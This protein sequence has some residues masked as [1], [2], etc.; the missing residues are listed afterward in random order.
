MGGF[1]M[2]SRYVRVVTAL[3]NVFRQKR[4]VNVQELALSRVACA[5][6][7]KG[8]RARRSPFNSAEP[9]PRHRISRN[10]FSRLLRRISRET[11]RQPPSP[12]WRRSMVR[13]GT[14]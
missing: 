9:R 14:A 4:R 7:Y 2:S 5:Y 1:V 10:T 13:L 3:A 11:V 6:F 8:G 12:F